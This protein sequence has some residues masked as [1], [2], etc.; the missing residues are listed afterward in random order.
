MMNT[1]STKKMSKLNRKRALIRIQKELQYIAGKS[2][3]T[4][5]ETDI[6]FAIYYVV[7][8]ILSN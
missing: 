3:N 6:R 2:H 1:T 4:A 7:Q 5:E 8:A